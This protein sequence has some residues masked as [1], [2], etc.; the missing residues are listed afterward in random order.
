MKE[1]RK[2][3]V[4]LTELA[5]GLV[6]LG[7]AVSVGAT[8]LVNVRDSQ[9]TNIGT[10]KVTAEA[11]AVVD[12][13]AGTA[14]LSSPYVVSITSCNNNSQS[15]IDITSANWVATTNANTHVT[16]LANA[17][18]AFIDKPWSC[19]YTISNLSDPRFVL[20]NTASIGLNE[21][22]NWFKIIVIVGVAAV[23]LALIFMAFGG[24]SVSGGDGGIGGTY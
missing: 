3:A 8:I 5:I 18:S 21:Y 19:N 22:G 12:L 4:D 16:T 10:Q 15:G 23:V 2:S 11:L 20:P 7:I 24:K 17:T 13:K 6:I 14:A 1:Y 9:I